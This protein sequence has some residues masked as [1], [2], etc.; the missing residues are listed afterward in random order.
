MNGAPSSSL[1]LATT[2]TPANNTDGKS[3]HDLLDQF[4]LFGHRQDLSLTTDGS[5]FADLATQHDAQTAPLRG[6]TVRESREWLQ[7]EEAE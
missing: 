4:A 7:S 3:R 2:I 5:P 1:L 6:R